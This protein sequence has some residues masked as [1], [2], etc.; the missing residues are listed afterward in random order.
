MAD[1]TPTPAPFDEESVLS[2]QETESD[3]EDV[4]AHSGAISTVSL[5][6]SC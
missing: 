1:D 6:A 4:E 5:V 3:Q 2:L